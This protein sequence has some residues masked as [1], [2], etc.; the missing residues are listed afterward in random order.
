MIS[1]SCACA[2][3]NSSS[4]SDRSR[5]LRTP[6][7]TSSPCAF[8]RKSP[9]G[10]GAPV[11]SSRVKATPEADVSPLLP[12][13]ICCTFTAVPHSSGM[14]F[15]RRYSPRARRSRSR[16]PPGSPGAAARAAP[17]GSPR[18]FRAAK[19]RLNSVGQVAGAPPRRGRCRAPRPCCPC[20]PDR[21]LEAGA[22]DTPHDVAEHLHEAPVG[23]PPEAR[24]CPCVAIRPCTELSLR[25][26]LRTVSSIPGI[27]S[28]APERTDTSSGSS[29]SPRRFPV[30]SLAGARAPRRP[31]PRA[32]PGT[33]RPRACRRR[34]PRS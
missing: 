7:T 14:R 25:P 16:R 1:I 13:T 22:V 11:V 30:C 3:G 17:A 9:D 5:V 18:R 34:T 31:A 6:E 27:D 2:S 19:I 21:V 4:S 8:W 12:N 32:R 26:R 28:R 33:C 15:R 10:P 24:R 20:A 29:G 23:V